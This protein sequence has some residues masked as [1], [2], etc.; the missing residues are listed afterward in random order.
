MSDRQL[1]AIY[2]AGLASIHFHP[3]NK[4]DGTYNH[5]DLDVLASLAHEMVIITNSCFPEVNDAVD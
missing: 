2:F 4:V 5:V 3:R 1:F